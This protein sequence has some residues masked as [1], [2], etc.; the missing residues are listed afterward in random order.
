MFFCSGD[1]F[2]KIVG[3][4][5]SDNVYCQRCNLAL[6][7]G[8]DGLYFPVRA[9]RIGPMPLPR[10]ALP[11]SRSRETVQDGRFRFDVALH[12]PLTGQLVVHYR[13][14]LV[15]AKDAKG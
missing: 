1:G 10:W 12:A 9:G 15:R 13:G 6:Q 5:F 2:Q 14:W 11:V 4:I 7:A 3:R 8:P